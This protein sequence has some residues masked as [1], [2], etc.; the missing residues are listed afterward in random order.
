MWHKPCR[1][2]HPWCLCIKTR[3][4][5]GYA[6]RQSLKTTPVQRPSRYKCTPQDYQHVDCRDWR[7]PNVRS[8]SRIPPLLRHFPHVV[9][10]SPTL[11]SI[12]NCASDVFRWQL[13]VRIPVCVMYRLI[14]GQTKIWNRHEIYVE[15][16]SSAEMRYGMMTS[17]NGNIFRV[18]GHLC[19]E[20]TGDPAQR[21]V[22]R[23]FDGFFDLRLNTRLSKQ[24]WGWWFETLSSPLWR[25]CNWI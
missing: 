2:F 20:F 4:L 24:S 5:Y 16:F 7:L 13:S 9:V 23:S 19:G 3:C 10:F 21:P 6:W 12:A 11:A 14:Q 1:T 15:T 25:H 17:S 8:V 22:T 18:T